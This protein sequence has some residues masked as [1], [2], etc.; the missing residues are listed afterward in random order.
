MRPPEILS[1][2][3]NPCQYRPH[4]WNRNILHAFVHSQLRPFRRSFT[5]ALG[6]R[7]YP[8]ILWPLRMARIRN[9]VSAVRR[10]ESLPGD[11]LQETKVFGYRH[12]RDPSDP[13][14]VYG[15][16]LYCESFAY[17]SR[18]MTDILSGLCKQVSYLVY[19]VPRASSCRRS[20]LISAGKEASRWVVR[21]IALGVIFSVT[22]L[23]GLFPKAGIWLMNVGLMLLLLRRRIYRI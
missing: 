2:C 9:D 3:T 8:V 17:L 15:K 18:Q 1:H 22:L 10:G 19:R 23:H 14:R 13:S 11:G 4:H 21:G 16:R 7:F 20:I 12:L 5:Y 6:P